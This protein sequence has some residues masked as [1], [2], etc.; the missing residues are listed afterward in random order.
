MTT[1]DEWLSLITVPLDAAA[2]SV[3]RQSSRPLAPSIFVTIAPETTTTLSSRERDWIKSGAIEVEAPRI[4]L[5]LSIRRPVLHNATPL[6][7]SSAKVPGPD[8]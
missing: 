6:V 7:E 8:V 3:A 4:E 1:S 5:V 2:G